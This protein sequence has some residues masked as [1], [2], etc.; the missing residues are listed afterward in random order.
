MAHAGHCIYYLI[1]KGDALAYFMLNPG[2]LMCPVNPHSSGQPSWEQSSS[3]DVQDLLVDLVLIRSVPLQTEPVPADEELGLGEVDIMLPSQIRVGRLRGHLVEGVVE[4]GSY[5]GVVAAP[6]DAVL[7]RRT[8]PVIVS[9]L[10]NLVVP[11]LAIHGIGGCFEENGLDGTLDKV[12]LVVGLGELLE[13]VEG[14]GGGRGGEEGDEA[15][16]VGGR[17]DEA[18]EEPGGKEH[19]SLRLRRLLHPL[20]DLINMCVQEESSKLANISFP[21]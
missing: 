20:V 4:D 1:L 11:D 5:V 7:V 6:P 16:P 8:R 12:D 14:R 2:S 21:G 15:A 18:V 17:D 10:K 13:G 3:H 19:S 9:L